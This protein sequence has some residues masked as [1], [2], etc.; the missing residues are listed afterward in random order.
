MNK[1]LFKI[2][3]LTNLHVGSG[4]ANFDIVDKEVEKDPV[5]G[6]PVVHG[7]GIKGALLAD[8]NVCNSD[9]KEFVFGKPGKDGDDGDKM[10][11][12][13]NYKF[14]D[15]RFIARPLRVGVGPAAYIITTTVDAINDFVATVR[16]FGIADWESVNPIGTISF[17]DKKFLSPDKA[18]KDIEGDAAGKL[19]DDNIKNIIKT[20]LGTEKFAI[21]ENLNDYPLPVVARNNLGKHRNLWYE[22][23]VP[24][25]S[26][27]YAVILHPEDDFKL[28]FDDV[29]QLGGNASVGNG[30]V[31]F[32][33]MTKKV[34]NGGQANEQEKG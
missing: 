1:K 21:A 9:N 16:G 32:T 3:C 5:T 28:C 27:F 19:E 8:E 17:G 11:T 12:A 31:K 26:Q 24:Y 30:Y 25:K 2:D 33:E 4:D 29:I 13:G 7:T 10:S 6:Y 14:L 22:E 23:F 34:E 15:A 18:V 20:I